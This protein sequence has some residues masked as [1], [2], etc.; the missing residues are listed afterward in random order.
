[1]EDVKGTIIARLTRLQAD[2]PANELLKDTL[3][4]LSSENK[5][6]WD[7]LHKDFLSLENAGLW[8]ISEENTKLLEGLRQSLSSRRT[9]RDMS[10]VRLPR[11]TPPNPLLRSLP[12]AT[13][14]P[15]ELVDLLNET[16]FLHLL[17]TDPSKVLPPGKSLLSMMTQPH[18]REHKEGAIPGLQEKVEEVLHRAFWDEALEALSSNEPSVQLRRLKLLYSDLH[19]ALKPLLPPQ[20]VLLETLTDPLSPTSAPLRSATLHLQEL[21]QALKERCAP[22]RDPYITALARELDEAPP[23]RL[24]QAVLDTIRGVLALAETMKDDLSHFVLGSMGEEQLRTSIRAQ[25]LARERSIVLDLWK[26]GQHAAEW[27][28]WLTELAPP[29][30]ASVSASDPPA[31][32]WPARL[33]QA[34]GAPTPVHCPLPTKPVPV[35]GADGTPAP[36]EPNALPPP[37][38]FCAPALL[39]IQNLLQALV[40]GAALRALI[41]ASPASTARRTFMA[42]IWALLL[43]SI[44][45]DDDSGSAAGSEA[46]S[47]GGADDGTKLANLADELARL[48]PAEDEA[49]LRAAV[50]RTLRLSDPA[51]ALLQRRLL[52]ALAGRLVRMPRGEVRRGVPE[53]MQAGL[54]RP[55]KRPKLELDGR[56]DA[57][58]A[59]EREAVVVKGFEEGVLVEGAGEVL[60]RLKR[61][62]RWVE[63]GW[64]DV[65][66]SA[67]KSKE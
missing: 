46:S 40:I 45:D 6:S 12:P 22:A 64:S 52:V 67:E 57:E 63:E 44:D 1:M 53:V 5:A 56:A 10:V 30:S 58:V 36:V 8:E 15:I 35:P 62:V 14:L 2:N 43:S 37:L 51:F 23:S 50:E 20:H 48:A 27:A 28:H 24:A 31:H 66:G 4:H 41:P 38:F 16:Y 42:R 3:S 59:E 65:V 26:D 25:A 55:G 21:L 19:V 18:V 13:L 11:A 39:Y 49:R 29:F 7:T 17:A 54:G 60:G 32:R 47:E 33:M 34:L 61:V 9:S